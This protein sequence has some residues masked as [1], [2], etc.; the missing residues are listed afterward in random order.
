LEDLGLDL[1]TSYANS[2][3]PND[4]LRSA[5]FPP[6]EER[7]MRSHQTPDEL[8]KQD[9]LGTQVWRLFNKMKQ[10]MPNQERMENFTWRMMHVN[11]RKSRQEEEAR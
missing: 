3:R 8:Q 10:Q 7:A 2:S 9:P 11:L 4:L 6:F 1:P 5:A